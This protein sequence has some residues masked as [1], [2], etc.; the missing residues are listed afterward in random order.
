MAAQPMVT[1]LL[2]SCALGAQTPEPV[3]RDLTLQDA[4]R[5]AVANNLQVE[6]AQQAR[7]QARG[8]ALA[9]EGVFDWNLSASVQ[10]SH[11]KAET[12][13]PLYAG[14]PA[15]PYQSLTENRSGSFDLQKVLPWGATF[16]VNESPS[17]TYWHNVLLDT[18]GRPVPGGES[19]NGA[20]WSGQLT[21]T[22]HQNLLQGAG[23]E[24]ATAP[25]VIARRNAESADA[26]FR[27]SVIGLV[28]QAESAYWAQVF[29]ERLLESKKTA[30]ALAVKHRAENQLR[31]KVGAIARLDLTGSEA[32]VAQAEQ[33]IL[34]AQNQLDNA[35]D[36]LIRTLY[37]DGDRSF[38][39]KAVDLPPQVEHIKLTEGEAVKM[40]LARR[41]ELRAARIGQ[42]VARLQTKVARD[43]L[44]PN[45]G[46]GVSYIGLSSSYAAFG[47]VQGDLS[48]ARYP[49]YGAGIQFSMPIENRAARGGLRQAAASEKLGDLNLRD[50]EQAVILQARTAYRNL[51]AAERG[52]VA[53]GKTRYLQEK[54]LD[55][56]QKKF[57][58]GAS[59]TFIVLQRLT[60]LDNARSA[61]VQA[62]IAYANAVTALETAVGNLLE[63]R[64][65]EVR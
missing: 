49:G 62:Q 6:I 4:I 52:V 30:L 7:I 38:Q 44:R 28:S 9:G 40:A 27:L 54:T 56:E 5:T 58:R 15:L 2:V 57:S 12:S 63:A 18:T 34:S 20:P 10:G 32:Q 36:A 19:I 1:V 23:T 8:G 26:T 37:P 25:L 35:R 22:Y 33:D 53:A 39:I 45:L 48:K 61:E 46:A 11:A 31:L 65:L 24:V 41:E 51:D 60:D 21:V 42:D 14:F 29:A 17:Y 13:L 50:Q 43:K 59:T 3:V 16:E 47:P 55:A 64:H